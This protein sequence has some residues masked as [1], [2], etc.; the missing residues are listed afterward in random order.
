M[1]YQSSNR[2]NAPSSMKDALNKPSKTSDSSIIIKGKIDK[3]KVDNPAAV[4]SKVENPAALANSSS[5]GIY[6]IFQL[7]KI[8]T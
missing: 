5:K 6:N 4:S 7:L 3:T 8:H 2:F 1:S